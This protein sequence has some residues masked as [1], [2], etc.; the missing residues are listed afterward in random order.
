MKLDTATVERLVE[1]ITKEVLILLHEEEAC[2]QSGSD[3]G[4]CADC[5]GQCVSDCQDK[6]QA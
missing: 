3:D 5:D 6:V 2:A 1:Q 4:Q